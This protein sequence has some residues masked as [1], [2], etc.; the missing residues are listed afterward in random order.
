[1]HSE[2]IVGAIPQN[3]PSSK[4]VNGFGLN[5]FTEGLVNNYSTDYSTVGSSAEV[6][7]E[8]SSIFLHVT[9]TEFSFPKLPDC[10]WRPPSQWVLS[11][12]LGLKH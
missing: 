4:L 7:E 3:D 9:N 11:Y 10:F 12:F 1:M 8:V 2:V 5:F 6:H